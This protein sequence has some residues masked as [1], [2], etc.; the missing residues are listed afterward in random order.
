MDKNSSMTTLVLNGITLQA[1]TS[2]GTSLTQVTK[3]AVSRIDKSLSGVSGGLYL[4]LMVQNH[5]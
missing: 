4:H 3:K 5:N 2:R 1:A